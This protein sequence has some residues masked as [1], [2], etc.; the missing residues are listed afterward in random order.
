MENVY[1]SAAVMFVCV[2]IA[3]VMF[4]IQ[5]RKVWPDKKV[6][7]GMVYGSLALVLGVL[8]G[9]TYYYFI[10]VTNIEADFFV[11]NMQLGLFG[12]LGGCIIAAAIVCLIF[13]INFMTL[14]D[15]LAPSLLLI[16][17]GQ[18]INDF[19]LGTNFGRI[20]ENDMLKHFPISV[21]VKMGNSGFWVIAV[22]TLEFILCLALFVLVLIKR[23]EI[24]RGI[25]ALLVM[26]IYGFGRVVFESMRQDSLYIGFVKI[27]EVVSIV[28]GLA[29]FITIIVICARKKF[30]N[31]P[32]VIAISVVTIGLVTAA[33]LCEFYMGS[34]VQ[35]LYTSIIAGAMA[36]LSLTSLMLYFII[37]SRDVKKI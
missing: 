15:A 24:G 8:G 3:S 34:E 20:V 32:T 14:F 25:N 31:V 13:K 5:C 19:F 30:I 17:M 33:F 27:A 11:P 7:I 2:V 12:V 35:V 22:F 4:D 28:L 29:A 9:R 1:I 10:D 36:I 37:L 16:V 6:S 18:R 23:K 21:Y 26:S